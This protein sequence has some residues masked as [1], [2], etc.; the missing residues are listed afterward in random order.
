MKANMRVMCSICGKTFV[1]GNTNT[2][3]IPNGVGFYCKDGT[4]FNMCAQ[5]IIDF[6]RMTDAE[7]DE[8]F[9]KHGL[10]IK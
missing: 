5:C 8:F 3:G 10:K 6:G 4:L 2:N 9:T 1:N 7:K